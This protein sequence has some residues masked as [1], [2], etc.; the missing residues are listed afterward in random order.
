M[1]KTPNYYKWI[2]FDKDVVLMEDSLQNL[3]K[4]RSEGMKFATLPELIKKY[5]INYS[6][7]NSG[8]TEHINILTD[9]NE[10]LGKDLD[11]IIYGK[12]E[13]VI[14]HTHGVFVNSKNNANNYSVDRNILTEQEF[15]DLLQGKIHSDGEEKQIV[16]YKEDELKRK[17]K[18]RI[19]FPCIT[20]LPGQKYLSDPEYFCR[21]L[22]YTE[23]VYG[24]ERNGILISRTLQEPIDLM[25]FIKER[26]DYFRQTSP[27]I[28][29]LLCNGRNGLEKLF[30]KY[31]YRV[32]PLILSDGEISKD[33]KDAVDFLNK[34]KP[35]PN[36]FFAAI[37]NNLQT[38]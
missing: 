5:M 16:V 37:S 7:F 32:M 34:T 35:A 20:V 24:F 1:N 36:T 12:N 29:P 4:R 30:E 25:K 38:V 2:F 21:D 33:A 15:A 17:R 10:I 13:K 11:G 3:L 18:S 22:E 26:V 28:E 27:L 19:K 9:T 31:A 8:R 23:R 14:V 6:F